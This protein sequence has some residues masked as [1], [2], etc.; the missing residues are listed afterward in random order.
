MKQDPVKISLEA[1]QASFKKIIRRRIAPEIAPV[2]G[3]FFTVTKKQD[4]GLFCIA[5]QYVRTEPY[6]SEYWKSQPDGDYLIYMTQGGIRNREIPRDEK[7]E[8]YY[9]L[10]HHLEHHAKADGFAGSIKLSNRNG[11]IGRVL[12]Q[13]KN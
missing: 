10:R 4:D 2:R 12:I 9:Y 1:M 13:P 3:A 8:L 11:T 7:K 6:S 5:E